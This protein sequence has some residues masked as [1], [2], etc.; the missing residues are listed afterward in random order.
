M[1]D[2]GWQGHAGAGACSTI[3]FTLNMGVTLVEVG[4]YR[5]LMALKRCTQLCHSWW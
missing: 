2:R 4:Q 5:W 1:Y 3:G